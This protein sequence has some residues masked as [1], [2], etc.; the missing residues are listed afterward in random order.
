M[1]GVRQGAQIERSDHP[2]PLSCP[3]RQDESLGTFPTDDR[4]K[5]GKDQKWQSRGKGIDNK[6]LHARN[7]GDLGIREEDT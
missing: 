5:K 3:L 2:I 6:A 1:A 4:A 7:G